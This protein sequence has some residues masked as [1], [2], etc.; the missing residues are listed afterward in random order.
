[1]L[2]AFR[3]ISLKDAADASEV[4]GWALPLID[5]L[6]CAMAVEAQTERVEF[7]GVGLIRPSGEVNLTVFAEMTARARVSV[8]AIAEIRDPEGN[9][10]PPPPPEPSAAQ[11]W[12]QASESSDKIADL[13]VYA[14]RADNWFDIYKAIEMAER[15]V[16]G[17]HDLQKLLGPAAAQLKSMRSTANFYRHAPGYYRPPVLMTQDEAKSLLAF[18]IQTVISRSTPKQAKSH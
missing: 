12:V 16:G 3:T 9:L 6:N 4:R 5:R 15:I 11:G 10:A 18:V 17:E 13:L 8:R 14:G 2:W 7:H 1:M